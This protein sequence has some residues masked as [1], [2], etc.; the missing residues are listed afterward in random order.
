MSEVSAPTHDRPPATQETGAFRNGF[1]AACAHALQ[2]MLRRQRLILAF[3]IALLPVLLPV[4]TLLFGT[5]R[6]AQPGNEV[7]VRLVEQLHINALGP[8]LALFF[9]TMLIGEEV[10]GQTLLYILTRPLPRSAWILG[11]FA[12]YVLVAS[13]I[14]ALSITLTFAASTT[15]PELDFV[16]RDLQLLV[17]YTAAAMVAVSVYGAFTMFLG[18]VT[19]WP[20][21]IGVVI[22]YGWQKAATAI[23]GVVDF[24]TFQKYTKALLPVLATQRNNPALQSV[25]A[26]FQ[27]EQLLIGGGKALLILFLLMV[28]FV[29]STI[30]TVRTREYAK[31]RAIGA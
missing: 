4:A 13:C 31:G 6:F 30:Y 10:E 12:A 27:R 11:R 24:L 2:I 9:A 28:I 7:F 15:L 8:L 22:L 1:S 3:A 25:I 23:P 20:I 18:A 5:S 16:W 19:K 26:G 17:Q 21:V 29:G 14:M